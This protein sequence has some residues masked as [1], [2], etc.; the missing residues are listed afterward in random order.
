MLGM[1]REAEKQFK[2]GLKN[3]NMIILQLYLS[4]VYVKLDQ[5]NTAIEA[6]NAGLKNFP[7]ET[8]FLTFLGRIFEMLNNQQKSVEFYKRVLSIESCNLE[9]VACIASHHFYID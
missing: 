6:L 2:S 4:K 1:T 9:A 7:Q 3:Q 8:S 5:P